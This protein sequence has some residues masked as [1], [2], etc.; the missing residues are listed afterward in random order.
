MGLVPSYLAFRI[1]LFVESMLEAIKAYV[2]A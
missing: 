2:E 1:S